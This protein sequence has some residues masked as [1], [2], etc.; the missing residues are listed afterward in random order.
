[1][2]FSAKRLNE[3]ADLSFKSLVMHFVLHFHKA[4]DAL[5]AS[6]KAQQDCR[7]NP[8]VKSQ[9]MCGWEF[10]LAKR[11]HEGDEYRGYTTLS[12]VNG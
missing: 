2:L 1:M 3:I 11:K 8:G 12:F 10:T 9:F 6:I 5:K 7:M 4:G